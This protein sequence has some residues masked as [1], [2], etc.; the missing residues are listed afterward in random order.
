MGAFL[1]ACALRNLLEVGFCCLA[2]VGEMAL[3]YRTYRTP[4]IFGFD[5]RVVV[6][7]R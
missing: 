6:G 1:K 4:A 3:L 2:F 5:A 7:M